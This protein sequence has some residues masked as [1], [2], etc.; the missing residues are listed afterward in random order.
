MM[1]GNESRN[2]LKR[3]IE[4]KHC[5]SFLPMTYLPWPSTPRAPPTRDREEQAPLS[6]S[7]QF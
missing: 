6:S 7:F 1:V 5:E 2:S 3:R 4:P